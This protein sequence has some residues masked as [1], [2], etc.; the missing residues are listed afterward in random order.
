MVSVSMSF[1]GRDARGREDVCGRVCLK[2]SPGTV[3]NAGCAA[4]TRW[5]GLEEWLLTM[6]LL[7]SKLGFV[8][9]L[10][11]RRVCEIDSNFLSG[12]A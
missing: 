12:D 1:G 2:R 10:P 3:R 9:Q 8:G 6:G 11:I 5:S 4:S 7:M